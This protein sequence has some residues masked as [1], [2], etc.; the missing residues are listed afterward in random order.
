M[1]WSIAWKNIWRNKKRSLVVI[2]AVALGIIAGVFIIGFVEGWSKQRLD[3]AVY[4]E[5]SHIQIH[6]NEYLKNE[7]TSLTIND[8]GRITA[9][10]DTL[11][12][13]KSHVVRTKIIA[14]AGTSWANTGVIQ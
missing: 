7:E 10:I 1:I 12:E 9:I 6:N 13:V 4:N 2:V 5:V 3:D 14:L 8:P 11:A